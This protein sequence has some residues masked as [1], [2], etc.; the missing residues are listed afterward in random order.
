M[1]PK[2]RPGDALN[3]RCEALSRRRAHGV[4]RRVLANR[5]A[6]LQSHANHADHI[7]PPRTDRMLWHTKDY[8]K[9]VPYRPSWAEHVH[10][11]EIFFYISRT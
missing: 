8:E 11:C 5:N 3:E 9:N 4:H 10:V 1:T 7:C 6:Q 2:C